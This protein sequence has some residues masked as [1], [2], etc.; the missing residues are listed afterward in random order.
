MSNGASANY[1]IQGSV[2]ANAVAVGPHSTAIVNETA[3]TSRA[4]FDS[5]IASLHEQ[6]AKLQLSQED[7]DST[8]ESLKELEAMAGSNP[9]PKHGAADLLG[10]VVKTLQTAGVAVKTIAELHQPLGQLAAWFHIPFLL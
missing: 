1:G 5:V 3:P 6:I 2:T 10:R 9:Q 8:H 7:V 4:E